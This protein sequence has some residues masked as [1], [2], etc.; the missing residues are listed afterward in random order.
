M[1]NDQKTV[2][3]DDSQ[4]PTSNVPPVLIQ[5]DVLP[6]MPQQASQPSTVISDEP[7]TD[8]IDSGSSAP[9]NDIKID[10]V[11]PAVVTSG[12]KK[13]FASG[14][15]IATILGLFLLV[16]GI[17]AG[18]FLTGQNQNPQERAGESGCNGNKTQA[19]CVGSC[20][21]IKADGKSYACKWLSAGTGACNESEQEC[22]GGGG[23]GGLDCSTA[24]C[25]PL[26]S[27]SCQEQAGA[28]HKNTGY[29]CTCIDLS[30]G[31]QCI[32]DWRCTDFD[33]NACPIDGGTP[34]NAGKYCSGNTCSV[35]AYSSSCWVSHYRS[36]KKDDP[37]VNDITIGSATKQ[38]ATLGATDC[39]AEQIDVYCNAGTIGGITYPNCSTHSGDC[40]ISNR[41]ATDCGDTNPPPTTPPTVPPT[42][43]PTTP[44]TPTA[45][46][47]TAVCQNIMA[48]S[49]NWVRM[50]SAQLASLKAGDDINFCVAGVATG[51]SFNKAK[52]TINGALQPETTFVKPNSG[53]YCQ[54]YV[55]PSG[56]ATFNITAQIHH[57]TLGWK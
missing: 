35:P 54:H 32:H 9:E 7:K 40:S 29:N 52:F 21:P 39:G 28:N 53:D 47:I 55:I 44:P 42:V 25:N 36:D 56:T 43:P 6:P 3:T 18:V 13:K 17:G 4:A 1:P 31:T 37:V 33:T 48:Y 51:G 10:T 2:K 12:P 19:S 11:M 30:S 38:S 26:G 27:K 22:G 23:G 5:E 15:V 46:A 34:P 49:L 24:L 45:P 50:S 8:I 16:G 57:V 20:S 41:Y 14:K